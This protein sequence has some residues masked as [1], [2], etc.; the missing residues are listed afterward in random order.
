[1][2][3][4]PR[5][6]TGSPQ[7]LR[8]LRARLVVGFLVVAAVSALTTALL[9][10][11][12]ARNAILQRSQDIA[13]NDLRA[14]VNSLAPE[15][16]VPPS[17]ADLDSLRVQLERSGKSRE[18]DISVHYSGAR[19]SGDG[20]LGGEVVVPAG[21]KASVEKRH[22]PAF[23]R[24]DRGGDPWLLIG[25]PV[26]QSD[27]RA[28]ALTVYAQLPLSAEESNVEALVS[29][30]QRGALPVLVLTVVLAL[31]A[32]RG[33]LRPVRGLRQAA[34]RI[35]EGKLDTRLEVKG[36]DE[37]ADLSRT[38]NDMAARLEESMAELRRLESNSRR[39]A[40]D[41]SHEL[42][43]PL[44]AMT[45]VTDVLDEDADSLDPDTASA[46]RL[47]SQETGK[48]ARMVED[49]MEVS[50]FDAGA[51]ALH[52]DE[53]DVGETIRK[54]LQARAWQK[55]VTAQ[56]PADVRAGL[57]PRRL[58][59]VVANLVG[60]ALHHGGE[61]VRV[62][63]HPP[64]PGAERL[65]IEISDSGPGIDPE[66]LPHVFDRFYKADSA[67]A[68]SEGSGLGLAIAI[69]NVRLHGGSLRAAN[70]PEGGAVFTVDLP[71]RHR[72]EVTGPARGR[73][74]V[75]LLRALRPALRDPAGEGAGRPGAGHRVADEG[76]EPRGADARPVQR[77]AEV[78]RFADRHHPC[79]QCRDQPADEREA[80][81][82]RLAEPVGVHRG[83]C[84]G[85][86]EQA[87]GGGRRDTGEQV[88]ARGPHGVRRQ[89]CVP[90]RG[91]QPDRNRNRLRRGIRRRQRHDRLGPGG[92]GTGPGG[93]SGRSADPSRSS[94]GDGRAGTGPHR[95]HR[96]AGPVRTRRNRGRYSSTSPLSRASG[97]TPGGPSQLMS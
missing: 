9:T 4:L 15:L 55:R 70:S 74:P 72:R 29:A 82:L 93:L 62:R 84:P 26:R 30:A 46:V 33:V 75:V 58:D 57:D 12:E 6:R 21:L 1:M 38:F 13:V 49:L 19:D 96:P 48:L 7:L 5:L 34:G 50:R 53:V 86:R 94:R 80:A 71:L 14:Q 63:L 90:R 42:R 78:P 43:T 59:V 91:A 64:E 83:Q 66:V 25:M 54:T 73:C 45:A 37:I 17:E 20:S 61:P 8:G 32:A 51:A 44:A 23:Q 76:A 79:G 85:A 97:G 11:Q 2:P 18:W 35:A 40:A 52:L 27:G 81:G 28:S 65:L 77:A 69:E 89:Q 16:P 88:R 39:F 31:L 92:G 36:A 56:L 60:N 87:V 95:R 10:Y 47:I 24:V 3:A 41:V 68:R 67:R 22:V